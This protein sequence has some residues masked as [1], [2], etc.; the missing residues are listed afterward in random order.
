MFYRNS[1]ITKILIAHLNEFCLNPNQKFPSC[2]IIVDDETSDE[3]W[4]RKSM[5]NEK[6][7]LPSRYEAKNIPV[8]YLYEGLDY[9]ITPMR[10]KAGCRAHKAKCIRYTQ[11]YISQLFNR[12]ECQLLSQ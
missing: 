12:E 10:W 1:D 11:R 3:K 8:H 7:I 6:C 2:N 9:Q 5:L 4:L